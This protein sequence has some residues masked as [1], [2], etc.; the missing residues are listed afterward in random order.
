MKCYADGGAAV[1]ALEEHF[2]RYPDTPMFINSDVQP[3]VEA[4]AAPWADRVFYVDGYDHES[5]KTL[6]DDSLDAGADLADL[7]GPLFAT[8]FV[9]GRDLYRW[10]RG[11]IPLRDLPLEVVLD[12]SIHGVLAVAGSV[13]GKLIGAILFGPAGAVILGGAGGPAALFGSRRVRQAVD[14]WMMESWLQDV[15][16]ATTD[17]RHALTE[18]MRRKIARNYERISQL[19]DLAEPLRAWLRLTFEDRALAVAECMADLHGQQLPDPV[20]GAKASLRLMRDADVHPES[21]RD[22]LGRLTQA[23]ADR[24]TTTDAVHTITAPAL[25]RLADMASSGINVLKRL[26]SREP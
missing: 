6:M 9:L 11:S 3:A 25:N 17:F 18:A 23:L 19:G 8:V 13:S 21:V 4:S 1:E 2:S 22:A 26:G 20:E 7:S 10:H 15:E 16:A 12:G 5:V 14:Q 24:P